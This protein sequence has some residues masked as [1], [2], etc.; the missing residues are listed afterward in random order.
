MT[1]T[2]IILFLLIILTGKNCIAQSFTLLRGCYRNGV[3][4]ANSFTPYL[5][6]LYFSDY[7]SNGA[8]QMWKTDGT[9]ENT[10]IAMD[11]SLLNGAIPQEFKVF[12]NKMFFSLRDF[13]RSQNLLWL[14]DGT[15]N[16]SFKFE[17]LSFNCPYNPYNFFIDNG[18]MYFDATDDSNG[19][20]L[21]VTDGS[22]LGTHML[23]NIF[24]DSKSSFPTGFTSYKNKVYFTARDSFHGYQIWETDGTV[25]GTKLFQDVNKGYVI[26]DPSIL[27]IFNNKLYFTGLYNNLYESDGSDS[28]THQIDFN[29][30]KIVQTPNSFTS[31]NGKLFF[32]TISFKYGN[33]LWCID[34]AKA[35]PAIVKDIYPGI[36]GSSPDILGVMNNKL[37]FSA[38]DG[39]NGTELWVT[40]GTESGTHLLK[41]ISPGQPSSYPSASVTMDN[42]L[43]FKARNIVNGF[44]LWTCDGT[45]TGTKMLAP[46]D[47]TRQNSLVYV[48]EIGAYNNALYFSAAYTRKNREFWKY[49][50]GLTSGI[51]KQNKNNDFVSIFPNPCTGNNLELQFANPNEKIIS[52][53]ILSLDG[54]MILKCQKANNN[55]NVVIN[56]P[57]NIPNGIYIA[58]CID[59]SESLNKKFILSR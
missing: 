50:T 31:C 38:D 1:K 32:I 19:T 37:Y 7:D 3:S 22:A 20:E 48:D 41:D 6:N 5:G 28:G 27:T 29:G 53:E 10:K 59:K 46:M 40:D 14:T 26:P 9:P 30:E 44:E 51:E 17:N 23:K 4:S 25:S 24:I 21:W 45:D 18:K 12:G 56:L 11:I 35:F 54:K 2:K 39:T 42:R 16:G 15:V 36:N 47:T 55:F 57:G 34:T 8:W 43:Y 33:E 58:H 13:S 49:E 52:I